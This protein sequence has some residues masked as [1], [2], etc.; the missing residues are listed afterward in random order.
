MWA[1]KKE[2]AWDWQKIMNVGDRP[3]F[4]ISACYVETHRDG[5]NVCFWHYVQIKDQ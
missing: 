1:F 2:V 3:Y 5:G 4:Q